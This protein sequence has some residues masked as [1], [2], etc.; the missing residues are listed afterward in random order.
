MMADQLDHSKYYDIDYY[1]D[2]EIID[3]KGVIFEKI[4]DDFL[5]D[6]K[7]LRKILNLDMTFVSVIGNNFLRSCSNLEAVNWYTRT[8]TR[9]EINQGPIWLDIGNNFLFECIQIK[10]IDLNPVSNAVWIGGVFMA[11]CESLIEIDLRPLSDIKEIG[12]YFFCWCTNLRCIDLNPLSDVL[13]DMKTTPKQFLIGCV[14]LES[15]DLSHFANIIEVSDDFLGGCSSLKTID[16]KPLS[17]VQFI[18]D[19]CLFNCFDLQSI[20]LLPLSNVSYIGK[21]FLS[22]DDDNSEMLSPSLK[23]IECDENIYTKLPMQPF[24]I[25]NKIRLEMLMIKKKYKD[26]VNEILYKIPFPETKSL[27]YTYT[28][29]FEGGIE[30]IKVRD[31]NLWKYHC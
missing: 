22:Y 16:L 20:D 24:Y 8:R 12:P 19:N 26:C 3:F 14:L 23:F 18:G 30:Y 10:E 25:C 31:S 28:I 15:I 27:L 6:A 29:P 4:E 17:N 9:E 7:K 5:R 21:N 11:C 2:L 1:K 13:L